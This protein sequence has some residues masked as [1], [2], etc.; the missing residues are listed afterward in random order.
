MLFRNLA[1]LKKSSGLTLPSLFQL[2]KK[3]YS[4]TFTLHPVSYT[5]VSYG[6]TKEYPDRFV[7]M[8]TLKFG[9]LHL[10]TIP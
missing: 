5:P 2:M 6:G 4:S 3:P 9:E 7:D 10:L 8:H 1:N